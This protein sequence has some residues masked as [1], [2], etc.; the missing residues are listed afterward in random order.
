MIRRKRHHINIEKS[1][2]KKIKLYIYNEESGTY[3]RERNNDFN[4]FPLPRIGENI[5]TQKEAY[6]IH[7]IVHLDSEIRLLIK[8]ISTKGKKL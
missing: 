7:E 3:K 2:H 1:K 6:F 8:K 4:P 5:Y